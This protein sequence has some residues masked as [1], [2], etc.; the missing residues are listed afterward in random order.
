MAKPKIIKTVMGTRGPME[1]RRIKQLVVR[2]TGQAV[3]DLV[4]KWHRYDHETEAWISPM[5]SIFPE[6]ARIS[7]S[8]LIMR[9]T[10]FTAESLKASKLWADADP[11]LK[12]SFRLTGDQLPF[13]NSSAPNVSDWV[14]LT[15]LPS[16][17]VMKGDQAL[18]REQIEKEEG[19]KDGA[20]GRVVVS[21]YSVTRGGGVLE[22]RRHIN[23]KNQLF[24]NTQS[25][26]SRCQ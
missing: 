12:V 17:T 16:F 18:S 11:D 14:E 21:H 2:N 5:I 3:K 26:S 1:T 4:A 23:R 20:C 25:R 13:N 15:R 7:G 22:V 9:G 6:T 10:A 24:Y 8:G 19:L